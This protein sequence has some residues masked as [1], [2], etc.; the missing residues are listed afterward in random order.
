TRLFGDLWDRMEIEEDE[1]PQWYLLNCVA[2]LE[3]DLLSQC[4]HKCAGMPDIVKFVVPTVTKTRSHGAK[5]MV[6]DVKVKYQGYVYAK[7]RLTRETYVA[8]Q[9]ID[10]CRSWMGTINMKGHKKLP[11]APLPLNEEE[12]ENFELENPKWIQDEQEIVA[13]AA[14]TKE[15]ETIIVDTEEYEMEESRILDEI[16]EEVKN[17]Y[18]SLRVEDMIK[19]TAKNKFFGEDGIVRRL[20]EGMVLIRFFTYGTVFEEWLDPSD[21]RKLTDEEVLKGLGGPSAPITQSDF[22]EPR[23]TRG[24]RFDDYDRRNQVGG[25]GDGPRN[26]RQDRTERRF[27]G[28]RDDESKERDNWNW[29]QQ[30]ERRSREGGYSDGDEHIRGSAD[31]GQ[32]QK[33]FW[34]EGDVDSQWG[35][36]NSQRKPREPRQNRQRQ[37][38]DDWSSFISEPSP[39]RKRQPPSKEETDDFFASLMSDLSNDVD[40]DGPSKGG[41]ANDSSAGSGSDDDFFASLM[42]EI[43]DSEDKPDR[44]GSTRAPQTNDDDD[45]FFASLE[46]E[47][48]GST[49][50]NKSSPSNKSNRENRSSKE[51]EAQ[52]QLDDIFAELSMDDGGGS[53]SSLDDDDD[54]F[55]ASL[56]SELASDLGE[57][58][59]AQPKQS[60][61]TQVDDDDDFFASLEAEL[62]TDLSQDLSTTDSQESS[63]GNF[64]DGDDPFASLDAEIHSETRT[65]PASSSQS[66]SP[67][68]SAEVSPAA[69][70]SVFDAGALQKRTVPQLKEL[71]KERGL[72][73]SGKKADLIE[74]LTS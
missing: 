36:N 45:D 62:N 50:S 30:N 24:D 46:K 69:V 27:R 13:A 6:R 28:G 44:N 74:R 51:M 20:K 31:Q 4:R 68:S 22:E 15:G 2:T 23:E 5:R 35:R 57:T 33:N 41:P 54:D 32:S 37:Q 48:R 1:E 10:L 59:K 8:I 55:F 25:F 52:N 47:I 67:P 38:Q 39:S 3:L 56:E 61:N 19:V 16:E 72:K 53:S 12:V 66:A 11:P 60:S 71:L 29:Y 64:V 73:V 49:G 18:K 14:A 65:E 40:S 9:E 43:S 70:K 21:V 17:V 58:E 42:S 7:L 63:G 34:A 26:R